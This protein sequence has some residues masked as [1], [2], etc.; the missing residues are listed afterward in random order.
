MSENPANYGTESFT[1]GDLAPGF[2]RSDDMAVL[3]RFRALHAEIELGNSPNV[4]QTGFRTLDWHFRPTKGQLAIFTGIPGHGKSEVVDAL[5]VNLANMSG[6]QIAFVSL[7]NLPLEVHIAKLV[8]KKTRLAFFSRSHQIDLQKATTAALDLAYNFH[9]FQ[10]G[11]RVMTPD[12]ILQHALD[13][14]KQLSGGLSL[15]IVDPWNELEHTRRGQF[16]GLQEHEYL[17]MVLSKFRIF[18]RN[19]NIAV[20]VVAHP[21]LIQKKDDGTYPVPKLYDISGGAQ[22]ANKADVGICVYRDVSDM[23]DRTITEV[24][25]QKMRFA[26]SGKLGMVRLEYDLDTR[27]FTDVQEREEREARRELV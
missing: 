22:W 27:N 24:H 11:D 9:F 7:E 4:G 12:S 1:P 20:W 19:N 17:S 2:H 5:A 18:G 13:L 3:E 16:G 6:W 21:R 8:E 15:L 25:V 26:R 10:P 14:H 23:S